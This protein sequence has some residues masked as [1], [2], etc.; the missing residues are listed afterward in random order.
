MK[1]GITGPMWSGKT[2]QLIKTVN[3][4]E[5]KGEKVLCVIPQKSKRENGRGL[6]EIVI[7]TP[8]VFLKQVRDLKNFFDLVVF[9]EIHL[10]EVFGELEKFLDCFGMFKNCI[11]SGL[12]NDS[13]DAYKVFKVWQ[14]IVPFLDGFTCLKSRKPCV[15]CGGTAY[16]SKH[17]SIKK[18]CVGDHYVNVCRKHR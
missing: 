4:L 8:V 7:N 1:I 10:Y 12:W 16:F 5:K 14:E 6:E 9:D 2:F 3:I 15:K 18:V 11:V 13:Y 17:T